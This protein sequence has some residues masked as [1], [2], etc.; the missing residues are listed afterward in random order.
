MTLK[1]CPCGEIPENLSYIAQ[2]IHSTVSGECDCGWEVSYE[3][4]EDSEDYYEEA[5]EAWNNAARLGV[6]K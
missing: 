4:K 3:S 1:P 5:V 6:K 2:R